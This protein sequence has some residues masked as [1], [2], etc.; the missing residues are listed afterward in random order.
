MSSSDSAPCGSD[1]SV[2]LFYS[3][4]G[5]AVFCFVIAYHSSVCSKT[6]EQS[7]EGVMG[8]APQVLSWSLWAKCTLSLA[9]DE[10]NLRENETEA[11]EVNTRLARL[12]Q[13]RERNKAPTP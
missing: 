11:L 9:T 4:L 10:Y 3:N 8:V 5:T 1:C 13:Q 2:E 12:S 6:G 7:F